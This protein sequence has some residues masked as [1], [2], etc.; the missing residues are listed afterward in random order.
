M[1]NLR[2]LPRAFR[3]L[4]STRKAYEGNRYTLLRIYN[5]VLTRARWWPSKLH[6]AELRIRVK[7]DES[8]YLVRQGTRDWGALDEVICRG[9]YAGVLAAI[10]DHD[11]VRNIID[12]GANVG[13]SVRYWLRHFPSAHIIAVELDEDNAGVCRRNIEVTGKGD[14]VEV[15]Q[16]AIAADHRTVNIDRSRGSMSFKI[17]DKD[18]AATGG[19]Q[20]APTDSIEQTTITMA[21]LFERTGFDGPIDLLKCDIEGAERELFARCAGWIERVQ[22]L[23]IEV[24]GDYRLEHLIE[25]LSRAG[26]RAEILERRDYPTMAVA[27][28]RLSAAAD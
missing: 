26:R 14:R 21:D 25:D 12:L 23:A 15:I 7:G 6:N 5:G 22:L 28:L 17:I 16:G 13:F 8:P 9:E 4:W 1:A 10:A 24:H 19:E 2:T 18:D 20:P 3:R 11:R 27:L